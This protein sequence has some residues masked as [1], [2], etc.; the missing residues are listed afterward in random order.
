[1]P[2]SPPPA[3]DIVALGVAH[4]GREV[5]AGLDLRVQPGESVA[6]VGPS[7]AGKTTLLNVVLGTVRAQTGTVRVAGQD[8]TGASVATL[9]RL[10]TSSIGIVFQ[11]G[12]LIGELSPVEN[13]ALPA[14]IAGRERGEAVAAAEELLAALEVPT[15]RRTADE[16]SGGERQRTALARALVNRPAL[17]LADEPTGALDPQTR[18]R[19]AMVVFG[20]PARWGC[21]LLV[22]T[23]DPQIAARADRV[24]NLSAIALLGS[25]R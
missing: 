2:D 10:R 24:A 18:D 20:A 7:G 14:L 1:M 16:L 3:L 4:S 5:F 13:V 23:H 6:L 19:V 15:E 11:H 21:G 22:V 25:V 9:A 8:V 12:E 17:I